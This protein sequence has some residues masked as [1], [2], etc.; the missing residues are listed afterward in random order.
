M[1]KKKDI[2]GLFF[3]AFLITAFVICSYFFIGIIND[4]NGLDPVIK[5]LL[6]SLVFVL[7]GLV[8]FYATGVGE[9]KQV[10][11]FSLAALILVDLPA[12]YLIL[13]SCFTFFPMPFDIT[14]VPETA[15]IA[16]IALGYGIPYTFLSGYELDRPEPEKISELPAEEKET[17]TADKNTDADAETETDTA[18]EAAPADTLLAEET[19]ALSGEKTSDEE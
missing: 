16:S 11:R 1:K 7:F 13:A 18:E 10:K 6:K 15:L 19:D 8:L 9:G 14:S 12:I 3:S 4:Q 2:S 5:T 17:D